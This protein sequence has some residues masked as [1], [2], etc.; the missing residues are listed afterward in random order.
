M[1]LCMYIYLP[2]P[3][4]RGLPPGCGS[5]EKWEVLRTRGRHST[6]C[7]DKP[8]IYTLRYVLTIHTKKWFLGAGFLGAPPISL[9]SPASRRGR[10][11]TFVSQKGHKPHVAIF[12]H[13][14][15]TF[16]YECSF[17]MC[18]LRHF[19]DDPVCPDPVRKLSKLESVPAAVGRPKKL[20]A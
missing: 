13:I 20:E 8:K 16:P 11:K 14:L 4:T 10:D 19:C 12:C 18:E 1:L 5:S 2:V 15:P 17:I 6:I 3:M 9:S 7:F